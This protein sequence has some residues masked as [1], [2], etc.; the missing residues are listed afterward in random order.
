MLSGDL[1]IP[2]EKT[3][4]E[5]TIPISFVRRWYQSNGGKGKYAEL[6]TA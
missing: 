1:E 5:N 3:R 4:I 6:I 2:I